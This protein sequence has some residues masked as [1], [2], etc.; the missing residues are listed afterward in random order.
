MLASHDILFD[1][2]CKLLLSD[3][4][5]PKGTLHQKQLV[6]VLYIFGQVIA[7]VLYA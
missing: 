7:A 6:L 5:V 2:Y 4:H 3:V 1:P